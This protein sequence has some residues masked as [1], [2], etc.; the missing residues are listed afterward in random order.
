VPQDCE[1]EVDVVPVTSPVGLWSA[2]FKPWVRPFWPSPSFLQPEVTPEGVA[3]YSQT[4]NLIA[5]QNATISFHELKTQWKGSTPRADDAVVAT[6]QSQSSPALKNTLLYGLFDSKWDHHLQ[7]KHH[8]VLKKTW[9]EWLRP[10]I[11]VY[12]MYWGNKSSGNSAPWWP[13]ERMQF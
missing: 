10:N 8:A 1:Q 12:L 7:N 13:S 2:D 11:H 9:N 4:Q 5:D 3:E 6:C